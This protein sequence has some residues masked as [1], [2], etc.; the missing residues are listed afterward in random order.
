L[1]KTLKSEEPNSFLD[2]YKKGIVEIKIE[3]NEVLEPDQYIRKYDII[4]RPISNEGAGL[5]QKALAKAA[6]I[7]QKDDRAWHY[8]IYLGNGQVAHYYGDDSGRGELATNDS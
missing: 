2:D 7:W 6:Y 3:G 5:K 8:G 1:E 4:A